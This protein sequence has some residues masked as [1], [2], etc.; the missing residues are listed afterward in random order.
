MTGLRRFVNNLSQGILNHNDLQNIQGGVATEYYH[1]T[2]AQHT[3]LTDAGD[4]AL[5]YHAT[6]RARA[7]HTGTQL[8]ST[9]SDLP[10]LAAGTYTPT[11]TNTTNVAASTAYQ[12]QYLRVGATVTV[13]G[14]VD[15]DPT[16]AGQVQ[17]GISI[18]VVSNFGATE[19]LA[20]TASAIAVAG[21]CAGVYADAAN[22]RATLEF[23]T[24]DTSNRAMFF[25]FTYQ[26]I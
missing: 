10:T 12:A 8:M 9:I 20:G 21:Q 1:F 16:A 13:S 14:K 17:L 4:S 24:T 22:D 19:D 2:N 6:D 11:L 23:I 7:N 18:P 25:T 3:D 26:I 15:I 5:H